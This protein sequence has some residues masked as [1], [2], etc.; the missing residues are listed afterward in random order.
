VSS[1]AESVIMQFFEQN[2]ET[3]FS[4]KEV[5][6][7]AV[8]RSVFEE[9]PRWAEDS[10]NALLARGFLETDESGYYSLKKK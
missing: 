7:R 9:D 2:P 3:R 4:R 10:L 5:S 8:K 6:R 1:N